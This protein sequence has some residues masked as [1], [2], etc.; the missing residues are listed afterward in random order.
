MTAI[1][2]NKQLKCGDNWKANIPVFFIYPNMAISL[3]ITVM[4]G[5]YWKCMH[6]LGLDKR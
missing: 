2:H 5:L 4:D 3:S 6:H 1:G